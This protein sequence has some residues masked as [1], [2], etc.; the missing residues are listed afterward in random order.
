MAK[1]QIATF[2]WYDNDT[3]IAH[4]DEDINKFLITVPILNIHKMK[5]HNDKFYIIYEIADPGTEDLD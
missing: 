4:F 1:L 3:L 2:K 5:W